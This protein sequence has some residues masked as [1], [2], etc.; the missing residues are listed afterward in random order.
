MQVVG[1]NLSHLPKT[2]ACAQQ[3]ASSV[4]AWDVLLDAEAWNG[5]LLYLLKRPDSAEEC[6]CHA[7]EAAGGQDATEAI[8]LNGLNMILLLDNRF[9]EAIPGFTRI[10]QAA[11]RGRSSASFRSPARTWG[12]VTPTWVTSMRPVVPAP[13][14]PC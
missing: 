4:G 7:A 6:L 11:E 12:S 10:V 1:G 9:D 3:L 8:A 14:M 5:R 2:P 13:R